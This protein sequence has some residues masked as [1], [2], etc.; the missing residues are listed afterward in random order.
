MVRAEIGKL[1]PQSVQEMSHKKQSPLSL[2][3]LLADLLFCLLNV[4]SPGHL[5]HRSPSL[6][7]L[8]GSCEHH[9]GGLQQGQTKQVTPSAM[10]SP[11]AYS[12]SAETTGANRNFM[13]WFSPDLQA[14]EERNFSSFSGDMGYTRFHMAV[15][16]IVFSSYPMITEFSIFTLKV[17]SPTIST[18]LK[19]K[20]Y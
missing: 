14:P 8:S 9:L 3:P 15:C 12:W 10:P 20:V 2:F 7:L 17:V 19:Y 1:I 18:F 4:N 11:V 16:G 5:S 13:L 6:R